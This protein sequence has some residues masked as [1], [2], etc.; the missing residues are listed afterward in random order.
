MLER[1]FA[2]YST[3]TLLSDY[4][5]SSAWANYTAQVGVST[6]ITG[7]FVSVFNSTSTSASTYTTTLNDQQFTF[8][9]PCCSTCF[10]DA[11][12]VSLIYWPTPAP[13][14]FTGSTVVD[15]NGFTL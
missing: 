1:I 6:T 10:I 14:G 4:C 9:P 8:E 7:S 5:V 11:S 3:D 13:S 2:G 15:E 12:K